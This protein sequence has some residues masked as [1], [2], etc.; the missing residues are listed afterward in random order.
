MAR[1]SFQM[2]ESI[3]MGIMM[4]L[5]SR[6]V[7]R[8]AANVCPGLDSTPKPIVMTVT[9]PSAGHLNPR[10]RLMN[11]HSSYDKRRR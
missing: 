8:S 10:V 6:T 3:E 7:S 9:C 1:S 11:T 2:V 5:T 4:S